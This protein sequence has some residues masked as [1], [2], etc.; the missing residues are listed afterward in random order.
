MYI[1]TVPDMSTK[2]PPPPRRY[3]APGTTQLLRTPR[4]RSVATSPL[5]KATLA[6]QREGKVVDT[7]TIG[8][9]VPQDVDEFGAEAGIDLT[10]VGPTLQE[11]DVWFR[12]LI[13][14]HKT[15]R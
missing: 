13:P 3:R 15:V 4:R 6:S 2:S 12:F 14:W 8:A 5:L 11:F 1:E 10:Q 7:T 9:A